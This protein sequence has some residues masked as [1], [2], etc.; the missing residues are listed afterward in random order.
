MRDDLDSMGLTC[1]WWRKCQ[2]RKTGRE[3]LRGCC[4]APSPEGW[5]KR[6]IIIREHV[7]FAE[8]GTM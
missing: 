8:W 7:V 5:N 2:D 4:N 3:L 1:H 6:V